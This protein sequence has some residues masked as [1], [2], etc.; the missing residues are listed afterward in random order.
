[1]PNVGMLELVVFVVMALILAGVVAL[2][3]WLV[4]RLSGGSYS[5]IQTL[6]ARVR[7]LEERRP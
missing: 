4:R 7:E 6:E 5:R 2:I 1:M 3:M